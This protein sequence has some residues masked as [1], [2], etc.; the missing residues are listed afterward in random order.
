MSPF[1][2][3]SFL[4]VPIHYVIFFGNTIYVCILYAVNLPGQMLRCPIIYNQGAIFTS[5]QSAKVNIVYWSYVF[6]GYI[7]FDLHHAQQLHPARG[8]Q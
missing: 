6:R 1:F 7:W 5:V 8:Q 2:M 4:I 3:S